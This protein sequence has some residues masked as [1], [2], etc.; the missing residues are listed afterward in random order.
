MNLKISIKCECIFNKPLFNYILSNTIYFFMKKKLLLTLITLILSGNLFSGFSQQ[1]G[2]TITVKGLNYKVLSTN[3]IPNPGFESGYTGWTD[4]TSSAAQL[5]TTNFS[6][7]IPGGVNNSQYLVGLKNESS[8]SAGSIGTGWSVQSGKTY[9]FSYHVKYLNTATIAGTEEWTKV[10]L[11]NNKTS[12]QEP[13]ILINASNVSGGGVWT[14]NEIV[15]TNANPAYAFIV[16]RFRWLDN[17]LGFDNFSLF[18]LQELTNTTSLQSLIDEAKALYK[19]DAV[20]ASEL[21]ASIT[22]AE[23]FLT[24]QSAAEVNQAIDEIKKAIRNFKIQNASP[25]NP[26]DVTEYIINQGFD[27]NAPTGWKGIGVINY[28]EVEF[29]QRTFNMYQK[30]TGLPAGRYTLKAKGFERPK[31]NDGGAAYRAGTETIYARFYAKA[32]GFAEKNIPFNSLYK[33]A[34]SGVGSQNGYVNSMASAETMLTNVNNYYETAVTDILLNEGDTL[35]I[36]AKS[37]F[38]Q[39]G[40]WA[41]FDNF[42]LEYHGK[43]DS[44]NLVQAIN[45]QITIAQGLLSKKMQN[46]ALIALNNA[47]SL[48]QQATAADPLVFEDLSAAND[49][50]NSS[51]RNASLSIDAYVRLETAISEGLNFLETATGTKAQSVLTAITTGQSVLNNLNATLAAINKAANDVLNLINKKIYIPGWMLGNVNDPNNNW[52]YARSKQSKNWIIFWE[53]GYG[54]DPSVL[55]DGG[56]RIDTEGILNLAESFYRFYADSLRFITPGAS[57]TDDYKMII[58]LRYT[59]DWEATGSGVDD[60]IGLLTLTAWSAQAG[61]HTLAHEV[62]H[63]FQYQIHCDNNDQN[64]W[65]YG[66]GLNASGGNG[67]WEQCAQ[68]QA[69][70]IYPGQQFTDG[71]YANYLKTAHKHILHETP[72][73]DNYFIQDYWTYKHGMDFIGRLWD[74]STRPEDPVETYKRITTITQSQF[75][76][77]MYEHAARFATWDIP[78]LKSYGA[79]YFNARTQPLMK[80]VEDNYWQIDSTVCVENYGYNVI[81]LNVPLT[82]D[83]LIAYFAGR[84]GMTGFRKLNTAQAGWRYGFVALLNDGTRIYSK[85]GAAS[86]NSPN[87]TLQF[88]SPAGCKQLWLVVTGAPSMHWRHAWDDNDSNDEQWPYQVKFSGTNRLGYQNIP[89]SVSSENENSIQIYTFDNKL[90]I[91]KIPLNAEI[92][93]FNIAGACILNEKSGDTSFSTQIPSGIYIVNINR[94]FNRKIVVN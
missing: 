15:F 2:D 42:R 51:I 77:E 35:T 84:A 64:G 30:I 69:F 81:K 44:N 76:D 33:H 31:S 14:K 61:G 48:A 23:S 88:E 19:E 8:T 45:Y 55:A 59:R 80:L 58:R 94:T 66:Y 13:K 12:N 43:Y 36:G 21:Q 3:L 82:K 37:D 22:K 46:T 41:L 40:Y 28:H 75:N 83:T 60:M 9:Y 57:K 38:Q 16:A 25:T 65:M 93:I 32:T 24:S 91:D 86:Y 39:N 50:I 89:N 11:T 10:S 85:T 70:K 5:T 87:D 34:Y 1:P 92:R 68:W 53:P 18:E 4:A 26:L 7:I 6:L 20:G 90:M 17:R 49:S 74:K 52:S 29:Y 62:G 72:R 71:R 54:E 73:Y 67:W 78:A 56:F 79:N 47:I 27:S 63:C